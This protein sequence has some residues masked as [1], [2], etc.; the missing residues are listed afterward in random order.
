MSALPFVTSSLL[1]AL[2]AGCSA[3]GIHRKHDLRFHGGTNLPSTDVVEDLTTGDG[4]NKTWGIEYIYSRG[5]EQL[6]FEVGSFQSITDGSGMNTLPGQGLGGAE[7]EK[8]MNDLHAGLNYPMPRFWGLESDF[9]LGLAYL[10]T[11]IE[12]DI[13]GG[14]DLR[15]ADQGAGAYIKVA[16][17]API[18]DSFGIGLDLRYLTAFEDFQ[19]TQDGVTFETDLD[20][21]QA[22]LFLALTW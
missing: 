1:L 17:M 4:D 6:G 22:T 11:T 2:C 16:S 14:S 8:I 9:G 7:V 21:F 10:D 3:T 12:S 20:Q 15:F 5:R 13:S 19:D 18:T